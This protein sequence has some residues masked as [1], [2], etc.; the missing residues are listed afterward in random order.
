MTDDVEPVVR[1]IQKRFRDLSVDVREE[2]VIRYMVKQVR[3]GRQ[4]DAIMSDAYL[5]AHSSAVTRANMLAHPAV[6]KAIEEEIRQ[7]FAD[8]SSVTG[9]GDA[10]TVHPQEETLPQ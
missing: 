3:L 9:S 5:A 10:S 7:Q 6:L 8:Y 2:R 4:V 1:S